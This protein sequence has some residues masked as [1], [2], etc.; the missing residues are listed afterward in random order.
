MQ[1]AFFTRGP[2]RTNPQSGW[3][4]HLCRGSDIFYV[5]EE[6]FPISWVGETGVE[7]KSFI[8]IFS[9]YKFS[10]LTSTF[11]LS[12]QRKKFPNQI[13]AKILVKIENIVSDN[14]TRLFETFFII[15]WNFVNTLKSEIS[16]R[17][18]QIWLTPEKFQLFCTFFAENPKMIMKYSTIKIF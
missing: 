15:V 18:L 4:C 5:W 6:P 8:A 13:E 3:P 14:C 2:N 17:F 7:N 11:L 9:Y 10:E 1:R 16:V 12:P